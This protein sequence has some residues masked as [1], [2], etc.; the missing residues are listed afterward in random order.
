MWRKEHTTVAALQAIRAA[1]HWFL[2]FYVRVFAIL[3]LEQRLA[4]FVVVFLNEK[5]MA[6]QM[7]AAGHQTHEWVER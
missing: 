5:L 4:S 3:T 7:Q 6:L 2:L 1:R